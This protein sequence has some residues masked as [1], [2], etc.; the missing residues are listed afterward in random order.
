MLLGPS[1]AGK[2][3]LANALLGEERLA[4]A[5]VRDL[6]AR[7]RHTTTAR[8][9]V[10]VPTGGVLIDSPGLRSLGLAG[11][12]SGLAAGFG[13]V[14]ALA[15]DCRFADCGHDH[16]PGCAVLAAVEAGDLDPDRLASYRKLEA[17]LAAEPRRRPRRR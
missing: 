5:A 11:D 8:E 10:V 3:S 9:L 7:G 2:S 4:T 12:G 6:D 1:G 17:E 13:D 15:A 16:E 14:A